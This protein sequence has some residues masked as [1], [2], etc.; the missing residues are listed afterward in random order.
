MHQPVVRFAPSPTGFLHLGNA[1]VAIVNW[2]FAT[3]E[4]G[5]FVLRIDDTDRERSEPTYDQAIREDLTWLGLG[6]DAVLRQSGRSDRYAAAFADL[7]RADRAYACFETEEE[8]AAL[9]ERQRAQGLPPRYRRQLHGAGN[10]PR[11]G[12]SYWRLQLPDGEL[13]FDD[14][15][16]GPRRFAASALSDPVIMRGDGSATYLFASAVDDA[17]LGISHVIR[18]EDHVSNTPLQLAILAA[19]D[20][21][22]PR[23]AHLPLIADAAG[24][25]FSKRLGALSLRNLREQGIEP[26]AIVAALAA[27][28]TSQAADPTR[29]MDDLVAIFALE[30][31]GRAPPRLVVDDLPRLSAT[32]LHHLAHGDAAPRLRELGLGGIDAAFWSAIRGN[33]ARLEDAREWWEVC[34]RP[35]APVIVEP[36]FLALAAAHLPQDLDAGFS[37]WVEALKAATGRKGKALFQPLRLALT[38]REHGPELKHLLPLI[39]R[40]RALERLRGRTA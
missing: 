40:G 34:R 23:F 29:S 19:L 37:D 14:L 20:H 27:L 31:Y 15:V 36:Q 24:R 5:K 13:S 25:P 2:L 1:R 21:P 18:G 38:G 33:L 39:G 10:E 30:D 7:R 12:T 9:R 17:E 16:L 3:R 8:L 11:G 6:W 32:V 26:R 35:L 22:P 4:R 28:G